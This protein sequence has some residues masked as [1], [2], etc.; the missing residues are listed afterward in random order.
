[1]D[2]VRS[3]ELIAWQRISIGVNHYAR[4]CFVMLRVFALFDLE[5]RDIARAGK[6]GLNLLPCQ[7]CHTRARRFHT[8][9]SRLGSLR[10]PG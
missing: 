4:D 2:R 10:L 6:A 9:E 7:L 8:T 3:T 1:M 5:V